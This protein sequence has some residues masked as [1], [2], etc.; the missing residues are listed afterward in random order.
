M[1]DSIRALADRQRLEA[2]LARVKAL[3]TQ[4][5]RIG[6]D[7]NEHIEIVRKSD[8]AAALASLAK[9]ADAKMLEEAS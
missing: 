9:I 1:S 8:L 6:N 5:L 2:K 4:V 7:P 3:P